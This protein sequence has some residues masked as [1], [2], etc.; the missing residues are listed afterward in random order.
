MDVS[1]FLLFEE[2]NR[3]F[4]VSLGNI[5]GVLDDLPRV[6]A[7]RQIGYRQYRLWVDWLQLDKDRLVEKLSDFDFSSVSEWRLKDLD[8]LY[9]TY[10]YN[11][12]KFKDALCVICDVLKSTKDVPVVGVFISESLASKVSVSVLDDVRFRF[13]ELLS[14][15]S[16]SFL[17][18]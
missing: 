3:N 14:V 2:G 12:K 4:P 9:R 15:K 16:D 11:A 13:C 6:G 1:P 10:G 8:D 17:Q 5:L 7:V 18:A